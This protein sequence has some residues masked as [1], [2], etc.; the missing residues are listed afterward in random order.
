[1][2][3]LSEGITPSQPVALIGELLTLRPL[4]LFPATLAPRT[5]F[6][7][8]NCR[9]SVFVQIGSRFDEHDASF[10]FDCEN[11]T[12]ERARKSLNSVSSLNLCS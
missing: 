8:T 12:A 5:S 6:G 7:R 3:L 1:M 9:W 11:D 2:V 4:N 10:H